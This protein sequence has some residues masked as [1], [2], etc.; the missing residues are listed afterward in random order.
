MSNVCIIEHMGSDTYVPGNLE[1]DILTA[2]CE[3]CGAI[4]KVIVGYW[5]DLLE[6]Y[7]YLREDED[8]LVCKDCCS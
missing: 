6:C 4:D 7:I 2:D 8:S 5:D 1:N 3:V